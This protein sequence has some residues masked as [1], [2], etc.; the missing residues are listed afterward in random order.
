MAAGPGVVGSTTGATLMEGARTTAAPAFGAGPAPDGFAGAWL[1]VALLMALDPPE[2]D[3][4]E[5]L[6]DDGREGV[7]PEPPVN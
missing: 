7:D 2:V 4:P 1:G 3:P 5:L 6:L